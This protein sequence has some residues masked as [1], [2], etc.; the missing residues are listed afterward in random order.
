VSRAVEFSILGEHF[1]RYTAEDVIP[2]LEA[3]L[4]AIRSE[5]S[6]AVQR[7]VAAGREA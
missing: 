3:R 6:G 7:G 1:I 5:A 2:R 4:D